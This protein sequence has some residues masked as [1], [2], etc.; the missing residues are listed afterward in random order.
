[1]M[2]SITFTNT[3]STNKTN[4]Y[5]YTDYEIELYLDIDELIGTHNPFLQL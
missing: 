5:K 2:K 1:M 4:R 3:K